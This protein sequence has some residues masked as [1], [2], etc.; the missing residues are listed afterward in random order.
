MLLIDDGAGGVVGVHAGLRDHL[1]SHLTADRIDRDLA[2]G[3]S[4][5][6]TVASAL[7]AQELT[8]MQTRRDLASGLQRALTSAIASGYARL[9]GAPLA[10]DGIL[11][12]AAEI[13]E[14]S[15]R[16]L[17]EGP[18]S[19]RGVAQTRLLLTKGAGPLHNRRSQERL[20]ATVRRAIRDLDIDGSGLAA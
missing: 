18:V 15:R 6:A 17:A 5:D 7:R 10:R 14:L 2:E 16:L 8:S 11:G 4:P 19:V 1:R 12:S 13:G 9:A 20:A 3:A